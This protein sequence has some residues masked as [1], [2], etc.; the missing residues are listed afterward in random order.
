[1]V[2]NQ[3]LI[4]RVKKLAVIADKGIGGEREA[5]A[6]LLKRLMNKHDITES[7][8]E[9]ETIELEW[10]KYKH[11]LQRRLLLQ[12]IYT[13]LGDRDL[14]KWKESRK[15]QV[16]VYCTAAE[17]IEIEITCEFYHRAMQEEL[18]TFLYAF[19]SK[20]HL[21]PQRD[22]KLA[23]V[24]E[25][26]LSGEELMKITCMMDGMTTHTQRKMVEG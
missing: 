12:V 9:E 26:P 19:Y 4:K 6:L 25:P 22:K 7:D 13:I 10:F 18:E 3:S 15:K 1:M 23:D 24:N 8:L 20:N 2:E 11:D 14:Y 17:K 16:G 21:F 5:A